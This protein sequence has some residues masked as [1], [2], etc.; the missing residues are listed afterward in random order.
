MSE[1]AMG[2]RC[3]ECGADASNTA[4]MAWHRVV[5]AHQIDIKRAAA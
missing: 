1:Q 3:T 2:W 5:T 4:S